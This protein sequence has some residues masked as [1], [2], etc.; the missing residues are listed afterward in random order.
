[1]TSLNDVLEDVRRVTGAV[2]LPLLVDVD[3]GWGRGRST[4]PAPCARIIRGRRRGPFTSRDQVAAKRCGHRPN[5]AI[6][7][8]DEMCDRVKS[9]GGTPR[10]TADF[11]W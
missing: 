6:V 3:T 7:S 11:S 10:P 5:K 9:R 8:V 1:M 4:S 2:Q